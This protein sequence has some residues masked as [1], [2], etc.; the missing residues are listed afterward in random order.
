MLQALKNR[1]ALL[2]L[3]VFASIVIYWFYGSQ[4]FFKD[5]VDDEPYYFQQIG[6]FNTILTHFFHGDFGKIPPIW[7]RI[8][9]NGWFIPAIS[10]FLS[11]FYFVVQEPGYLRLLLFVVNLGLH[12]YIL[13]KVARLLGV[14][15]MLVFHFVSLAF[16][17][18]TIFMGALVGEGL[19]SR[20]ALILLIWLYEISRERAL[21]S[22][23]QAVGIGALLALVVY[24]RQNLIVLCPM[25]IAIQVLD[26]MRKSQPCSLGAIR[27]G[28][29]RSAVITLTFL[30]LFLPW[31]YSLSKK[32]GG[33]YLTTTSIQ[34]SYI[35]KFATPDFERDRF[36]DGRHPN[37]YHA[38]TKHYLTLSKQTG[39]SFHDLV[40]RDKSILASEVPRKEI[41]DYLKNRTRR[42]FLKPNSF[43]ERYYFGGIGKT[44]AKGQ[45]RPF[46]YRILA[47]LNSYLGYGILLLGAYSLC[48]IPP[49]EQDG[50]FLLVS[51]KLFILAL[52]VSFLAVGAH[53]R[54][55]AM[56]YPLLILQISVL[57]G[58]G[59]RVMSLRGSYTVN[60]KVLIGLQ[61]FVPLILI[62]QVIWL[63]A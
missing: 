11:P 21:M 2:I 23:R 4:F 62:A 20:L 8:L 10:L 36:P 34:M 24:T 5:L 57:A 59:F 44:G 49:P 60:E 13:Y 52:M 56:L 33:P 28:M 53:H 58:G 46:S 17:V 15:A 35:W 51:T 27:S 26:H 22:A 3:V 25:V 37:Q 16:P 1:N 47:F 41:E 7:D 55:L 30:I 9:G 54:H 45:E 29:A 43:V 61:A 6:K 38:W 32:F 48:I 19:A 14:K 18:Y 42:N 50:A 12:L 31:S 39:E 40:A 63:Y